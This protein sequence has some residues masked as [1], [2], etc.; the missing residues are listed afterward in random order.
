MIS[1]KYCGP[2]ADHSGYGEATRNA[3]MALV[4][5]GVDVVTER[6]NFTAKQFDAGH[7]VELANN[8]KNKKSPYKIKI[9]HV[10][11]DIY[12]LHMEQ[13]KYHIGHLFWE[14]DRLPK[15]WVTPCN[16]MNEIWTGCEVTKEAIESSGVKTPVYIYPQAI[17]VD[18]NRAK[19]FIIKDQHG[20]KMPRDGYIF[21]SIFEWNERKNPKALLTAFWKEFQNNENTCL[22]IKT[23]KGDYEDLGL[24]QI[25]DEARGWKEELGLENT[26]PVFICRKLLSRE[27]ML[28]FHSTGECFVSAHR[29]EGWG[30]PQVEASTIG[31]LVISTK[32][33]GIHGHW[34]GGLYRSVDYTMVP[35]QKEYNRYYEV[36]MQWAEVSEEHLRHRLRRAYDVWNDPKTKRLNAL[37]SSKARNFAK[38]YLSYEAVGRQMADRINLIA[39]EHKL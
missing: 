29:G 35:I 26:A 39:Q 19:P 16:A 22:L 4:T 30:L 7:I 11:P 9:L 1:V 12:K 15:S 14:T 33:G 13:G 18:V 6:V 38:M 17:N 25:I 10:T 32:R 8:L 3:I 34:Q 23:H 36:G 27:E 20:E 31:N 24:K 2:Y 28:R 5:A 21:Y 37:T